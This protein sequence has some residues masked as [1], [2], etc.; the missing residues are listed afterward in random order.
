MIGSE[1]V[2][3]CAYV[4]HTLTARL[5]SINAFVCLTNIKERYQFWT[6]FEPIHVHIKY[7]KCWEI[8]RWFYI[9][10]YTAVTPSWYFQNGWRLV[11][12]LHSEEEFPRSD[13]V[14][15]HLIQNIS[16]GVNEKDSTLKRCWHSIDKV[17]ILACYLFY[18]HLPFRRSQSIF[19]R[20]IDARDI[21][22]DI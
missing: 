18:F 10:L 19:L 5:S 16:Y 11:R 8:L 3:N 21:Y 22:F 7:V 14:N 6:K 1:A 9:R 15:I 2:L 12:R 13:P 20:C 17:Y 4:F